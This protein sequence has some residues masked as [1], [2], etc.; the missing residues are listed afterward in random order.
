[1]HDRVRLL[2]AIGVVAAATAFNYVH[3]LYMPTY[4]TRQLHIPATSSFLGAVV[5]GAII[6]LAA[7]VVGSLSDRHGRF[8][9]MLWS[10]LCIALSSYPLFLILTRWPSVVSLVLVQALVGFLIAA[11]LGALPALLAD[12]FPTSS[13]GTGLALS[14]NFS[15]TL[16]GG[17]APLI[18][19]W[20]ITTSGSKLAPSFYVISTAL[21]SIG[22]VLALARR[23]QANGNGV[24]YG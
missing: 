9:V 17:F 12:I 4:A 5:T 16:F 21:L 2:L 24:N 19:T 7:P 18:V 23:V 13:R 8:R 14:Y 10:L 3:K 11:S 20:L 6:M 1:V 22:A 15:V